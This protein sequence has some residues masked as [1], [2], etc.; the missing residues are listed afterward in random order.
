MLKVLAQ[1]QTPTAG[2]LRG[3]WLEQHLQHSGGYQF[4]GASTEMT[5]CLH[6]R[7]GSHLERPKKGREP[8]SLPPF[9]WPSVLWKCVHGTCVHAHMHVH[10][11]AQSKGRSIILLWA[12]LHHILAIWMFHPN[13][14]MWA[15]EASR[16]ISPSIGICL[17][18][19]VC[20]TPL[21]PNFLSLLV[22]WCW[23]L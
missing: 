21:T 3:L 2:G 6:L 11:H 20:N 12:F 8:G 23:C 14:K 16:I 10:A 22:D 19:G 13:A 4:L 15:K 17:S 18:L 9:F 5:L 1:S 7:I